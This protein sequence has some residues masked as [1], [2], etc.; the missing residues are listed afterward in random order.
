MSEFPSAPSAAAAG[1]STDYAAVFAA[2]AAQAPETAGFADEV[3]VLVLRQVTVEGLDVLLQHH[4]FSR[5]VRAVVEFGGYG[6]QVSD[7]LSADGPVAR[8][9]PDLIVLALDLGEIDPTYGRP[10]WRA[11]TCL[12]ELT[13]LLDLLLARTTATVVVHNFLPPLWNENGL[14]QDAE[15]GDIA[16]QVARV[17]REVVQAVRQH[18]P[19]LVLADLEALLRRLGAAAALDDRARLLWRAP[20]RRPFLDGWAQLVSRAACALKGKAK[21]V[22]V[23]DCDNTLWGGV[24]GE[25]GL[26]G[27]ALDPQQHPGRSFHEFQ[28]TVLHL[29]ER[30]VL[31]ALCSKNNE[32][33]VFEVLDHHPHSLVKR[34]HLAA[35]RI[36]WQDKA[37]N[38]AALAEELNLGLDAFVFVDDNPLE[39]GL[40]RQML[41][42]V[43][44][45]QV[46]KKLHELP[47]MLLQHGLFDTLGFT[48]EDRKRA[49][50]YQSESQRKSERSSFADLDAY[51]RS[52]ETVATIRRATAA[53]LA[54]VAQLTQKTNQFN[55]TTRRCAEAEL[56]A[57]AAD[58]DSAV[59]SLSV[60]DRFGALGLVGVLIA[61]REGDEGRID[62]FLM[63]CRALGRRL[64]LAMA[65]QCLAELSR[66]WPVRRWRAEYIA[67]AKNAQTADFWLQLGFVESRR[68]D[69]HR[70]YLREADAG[71]GGL[72]PHIAIEDT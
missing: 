33:D 64:E 4:L 66:Q 37:S 52:L 34:R 61:R 39:C 46:P 21:K 68:D 44:V 69:T 71:T 27:I 2:V 23:L 16:S 38:I 57:L 70:L 72:A 24:V 40:V 11:D 51:L 19:R 8:L 26:D 7:V 30:G 58:P 15:G 35:W 20:Y 28:T 63:S 3:R 55:L 45:L 1:G 32:A 9:K 6:T 60:R 25:D 48:A 22:L 31:L 17:N 5:R 42:P 41:P 29:A 67:T 14:V 36:D 62:N 49:Q 47:A 18:A 43:T 10:G 59:Y 65:E 13:G 56:R 12:H 54:R 50:L 53:E